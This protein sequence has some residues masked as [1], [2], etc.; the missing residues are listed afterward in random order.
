MAD[1]IVYCSIATRI[2]GTGI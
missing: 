1:L 2:L